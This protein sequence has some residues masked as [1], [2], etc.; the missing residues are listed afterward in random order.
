M[1]TCALAGAD[2]VHLSVGMLQQMLTSSYESCVID[3]EILGAAF[4]IV[5]GL[6]VSPENIALDL[7]KR[8]GIGG[9]YL[10][11]ENTARHLCDVT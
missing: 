3:D 1:L 6:E 11:E 8:V 10:G 5:R 9:D 4:R 7:I 2:F